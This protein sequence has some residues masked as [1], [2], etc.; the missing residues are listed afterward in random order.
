L[1]HELGPDQV[2][3]NCVA[4][5]LASGGGDRGGRSVTARQ[6]E[7]LDAAEAVVFLASEGASFITGTTLDVN[8]GRTML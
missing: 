7:A 2:T 1:V 8:G 3:V 5:G 6:P 4:A